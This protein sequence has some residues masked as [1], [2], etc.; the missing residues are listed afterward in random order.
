MTTC[1]T[2]PSD[3]RAIAQNVGKYL[4]GLYGQRKS[5]APALIKS[6]MRKQKYPQAWDCWALSLFASR[7]DFDAYHA[8]IGEPCDFNAMRGAML[9][10]VRPAAP[11][12]DLSTGTAADLLDDVLFFIDP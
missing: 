8:A 1:A 6:G 4:V 5:Y 10:A 7:A 3:K 2:A 11:S 9:D 12:T